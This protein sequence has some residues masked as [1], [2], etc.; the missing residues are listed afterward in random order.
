MKPLSIIFVENDMCFLKSFVCA[1]RKRFRLKY[2]MIA[3]FIS[4]LSSTTFAHDV[5]R[6]NN[7]TTAEI[8]S[9]SPSAMVS[10]VAGPISMSPHFFNPTPPPD[11]TV[12]ACGTSVPLT[13]D[14]IPGYS[15]P[16][17][18]DGSTGTTFTA[19]SS[20]TYWWQVTGSN[21]V[22][23]GDFSSGNTGFTSSYSMPASCPG[24]CCGVLSNEGT[25]GVNANPHNLHTNFTSMGDHTSGSG[26]MLIVNGASAANVTVWKENIT[27]QPN[28]NYVFSVW[29]T[30][31][32]S[33]NPA[34][35]QFSINGGTLGTIALSSSL[36]NGTWQ[37][38]TTVW[39]SGS[40]SGTVP[41]ALVNQNT[42]SNGND[43]AI[44]DIVFAPV[45]RQNIIVNLNPIP[46]LTLSGPNTACDA[47]DLT[48][49]IN[50]YDPSTY[51][52]IYKDS[53][54]NTVSDPQNITQ[55]GTYTITEQNKLTGCESLPK[56]TTV[57]IT[58]SPPQP[59]VNSF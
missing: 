16:T 54:G 20:G 21:I 5:V 6:K 7:D 33:A 25:Y 11:I 22:A 55:S 8:T 48:Q 27:I 50:G 13:S 10:S 18:S 41:I 1:E 32:T 47:Y 24:C 36:S 19:T 12:T 23:N 3:A 26:K 37:Y 42:A 53:S 49:T 29:A 56:T 34:I 51:T 17:W 44:D 14:D 39:N 9:V 43:F 38:F 15:N 45:Y 30:S 57:T 28:T 35:L 52:Y 31:V 2:S 59:S 58:P 40:A 4:A 46:V